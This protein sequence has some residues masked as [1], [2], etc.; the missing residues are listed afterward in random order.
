MASWVFFCELLEARLQ[1]F[2]KFFN[3]FGVY[4]CVNSLCLQLLVGFDLLQLVEALL[5]FY[6]LLP[7]VE[8]ASAH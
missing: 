6:C 2:E 7:G 5:M 8:H 3:L 4:I 1:R